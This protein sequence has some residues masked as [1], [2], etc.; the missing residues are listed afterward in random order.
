MKTPIGMRHELSVKKKLTVEKREETN[1]EA[2]PGR[3]PENPSGEFMPDMIASVRR[4]LTT[5]GIWTVIVVTPIIL[6]E[7]LGD[8]IACIGALLP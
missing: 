4:G 7:N 2:R 3:L 5:I 1:P 6:I 8:L